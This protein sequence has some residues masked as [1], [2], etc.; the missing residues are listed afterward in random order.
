MDVF[1][2]SAKFELDTTESECCV[3]DLTEHVEMLKGLLNDTFHIKVD[4]SEGEQSLRSLISQ[5]ESL[6][7]LLNETLVA[8]GFGI[9]LAR[10]KTTD[11]ETTG[12]TNNQSAGVM[13]NEFSIADLFFEGTG[14]HTPFKLAE[15]GVGFVGDAVNS[16]VEQGVQGYGDFGRMARECA[17][18]AKELQ[19]HIDSLKL[20]IGMGLMPAVTAAMNALNRFA[21]TESDMSKGIGYANYVY[22]GTTEEIEEAATKAEYIIQAVLNLETSDYKEE[23]RR[24]LK[25]AGLKELI[26]LIPGF[27]GYINTQTWEVPEGIDALSGYLPEW[28]EFALD[29][30]GRTA[31]EEWNRQIENAESALSG[32]KIEREAA[33]LE[34]EDLKTKVMDEADKLAGELEYADEYS[35]DNLFELISVYHDRYGS[36]AKS[37]L[38]KA[39]K[40]YMDKKS[41]IE[42]LDTQISNIESDIQT[43]RDDEPSY[44]S[45]YANADETA[46]ATAAQNAYNESLKEGITLGEQADHAYYGFFNSDWIG[47]QLSLAEEGKESL[48]QIMSETRDTAQEIYAQMVDDA[49]ETAWSIAEAFDRSREARANGLATAQSVAAGLADGYGAIA[50]QANAIQE[51]LASLGSSTGSAIDRVGVL[52]DTLNAALLE[53][54]TTA[55]NLDGLSYVPYNDYLSYLHKGEAVL[56]AAQADD[57]RA[58]RMGVDLSAD[59][60]ASAVSGAVA[61]ALSGLTVQMD[62]QTVGHLVAP[63][64]SSDIA[65]GMIT[66][67]HYAVAW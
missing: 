26:D 56:T 22:Y 4:T 50:S 44:V 2:L 54:P 48:A 15:W 55:Y 60:I 9:G 42:D 40:E 13:S 32:L 3:K 34:L 24:Q 59:A 66:T 49:G 27:A 23:E 6:H 29:E 21:G 61:R 16:A 1:D 39:R 45:A 7:R 37:E 51:L 65:E 58:G 14:F 43:A 67:R 62:G 12:S 19:G 8:N 38:E 5:A 41:K 17:E 33:K 46:K 28:K 57:W 64:V 52:G 25:K 18:S 63:T 35:L 10:G 31:Y 11:A 30:A 20:S 36:E 47:E 53:P